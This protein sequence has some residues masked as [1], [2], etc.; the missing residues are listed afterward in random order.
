MRIR[1]W[2]QKTS[3]ISQLKSDLNTRSDTFFVAD[4][5]RL[6]FVCPEH[7]VRFSN[8]RH[9]GQWDHSYRCGFFEVREILPNGDMFSAPD[10]WCDSWDHLSRKSGCEKSRPFAKSS[11]TETYF[12]YRTRGQFLGPCSRGILDVRKQVF[13]NKDIGWLYKSWTQY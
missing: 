13:A 6:E 5:T 12:R 8:Q 3:Q 9:S 1:K 10:P 2:Q 4:L 7:F 11:L